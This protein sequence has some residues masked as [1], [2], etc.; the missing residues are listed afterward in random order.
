MVSSGF[1]PEFVK[2]EKGKDRPSAI[3]VLSRLSVKL[4]YGVMKAKQYINEISISLRFK[5]LTRLLRKISE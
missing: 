2:T 3:I 5:G 1:H 4:S